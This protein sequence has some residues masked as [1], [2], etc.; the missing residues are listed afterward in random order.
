MSCI[1]VMIVLKILN[2]YMQQPN[3][4]QDGEDAQLTPEQQRQLELIEKMPLVLEH[5][6]KTPEEKE[7]ILGK[8]I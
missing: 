1:L 4:L 3:L 5:E 2:P 8:Y 7:R 6:A